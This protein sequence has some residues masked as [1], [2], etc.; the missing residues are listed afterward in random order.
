MLSETNDMLS[1]IWQSQKLYC[2]RRCVH[3]QWQSRMEDLFST[4]TPLFGSPFYRL[5]FYT[6]CLRFYQSFYYWFSDF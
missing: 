2:S 6:Y 5:K 3:Q 4:M 1:T